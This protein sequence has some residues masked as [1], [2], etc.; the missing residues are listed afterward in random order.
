MFLGESFDVVEAIRRLAAEVDSVQQVNAAL[1][2]RVEVL[3]GKRAP[4]PLTPAYSA[5]P[6]M[7]APTGAGAGVTVGDLVAG[8]QATAP[9]QDVAASS[10]TEKPVRRV[11][12]L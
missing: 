11:K 10:T 6:S 1:K 3:E 2:A 4:R 12:K 9:G 5:E 8:E 7:A